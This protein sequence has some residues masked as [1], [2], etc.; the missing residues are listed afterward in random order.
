LKIENALILTLEG[1]T[2]DVDK[3]LEIFNFFRVGKRV[4]FDLGRLD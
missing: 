1:W 2:D 3:K 4:E